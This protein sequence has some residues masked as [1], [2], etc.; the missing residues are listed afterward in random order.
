MNKPPIFNAR[1]SAAAITPCATAQDIGTLTRQFMERISQSAED[2][3]EDT[4]RLHLERT[5]RRRECT[6]GRLSCGTTFSCHTLE[7][8]ARSI[9]LTEGTYTLVPLFNKRYGRFLPRVCTIHR[10]RRLWITPGNSPMDTQRG[11]LV[12]SLHPTCALTRTAETLDSLMHL[13]TEAE[14]Q[15]K[16]ISLE[17]GRV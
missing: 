13:I 2:T 14:R 16:R 10:D 12:G 15:G 9:T 6:V 17:V 11:I 1:P 5:E 4:L 7:P 3:Q 8:P